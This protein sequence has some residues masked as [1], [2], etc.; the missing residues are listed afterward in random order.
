VAISHAEAALT[1]I[2]WSGSAIVSL[3]GVDSLGSSK[4]HHSSVWVSLIPQFS[5]T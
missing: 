5:L 1:R 4:T 3:A 2:S